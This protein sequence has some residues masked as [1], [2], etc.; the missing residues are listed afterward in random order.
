MP[1]KSPAGVNRSRARG[2][3][4]FPRRG[5]RLLRGRIRKIR[6]LLCDVDGVLTDGGVYMGGGLELK[7]FDIQDGLGL[8]LLRQKGIQVGWVSSRPSEATTQRALDL[9]VDHL[10]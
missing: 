1:R 9:R 7:R 2:A 5:G 3:K 4:T 8:V 6:M 10:I